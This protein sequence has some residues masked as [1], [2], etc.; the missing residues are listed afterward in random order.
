MFM[1]MVLLVS[2][3]LVIGY[4]IGVVVTKRDVAKRIERVV[5]EGL[6]DARSPDVIEI[7]YLRGVLMGIKMYFS[8]WY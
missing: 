7:G 3:C 2:I 5:N 4:F 8:S 6:R 1:E